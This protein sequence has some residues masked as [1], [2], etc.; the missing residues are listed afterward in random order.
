MPRAA[1]QHKPRGWRP[2]AAK[3]KP[4]E[5]QALYNSPRWRGPDGLRAR[6]LR[7][8]PWC[9]ECLRQG[10]KPPR[11]SKEV[12]HI[13]PHKGDAKLCYSRKNLQGLC[14]THHSRKTAQQDGGFGRPPKAA[15]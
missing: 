4:K 5:W 9:A 14:R 15:M 6:V 8:E 12:D 3:Q 7:E 1:Q 11:P 13:V 10:R 2:P